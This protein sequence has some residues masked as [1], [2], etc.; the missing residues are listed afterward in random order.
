MYYNSFPPPA[1][2]GS[3]S[4]FKGPSALFSAAGLGAA[5]LL[6]V[7]V[8]SL[9]NFFRFVNLHFGKIGQERME[10]DIKIAYIKGKVS[11]IQITPKSRRPLLRMKKFSRYL[12]TL[13]PSHS[14]TIGSPIKSAMVGVMSNSVKFCSCLPPSNPFPQKNIG[15]V[16]SSGLSVPWVRSWPP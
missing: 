3:G 16:M 11:G 6:V 4:G 12:K 7:S 5:P 2:P 13:F 15:M 10:V 1:L 8:L 14:R 9:T